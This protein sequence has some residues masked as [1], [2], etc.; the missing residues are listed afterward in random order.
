MG[1]YNRSGECLQCGTHWVLIYNWQVSSLKCSEEI[2]LSVS[3]NTVVCITQYSCLCHQ[4]LLS[5]SPNPN[6]EAADR[7]SRTSV[8]S[9]CLLETFHIRLYSVPH[10]TVL[11]QRSLEFMKLLKLKCYWSLWHTSVMANKCYLLIDIGKTGHFPWD[12]A[13]VKCIGKT[14]AFR[15]TFLYMETWSG[16][17]PNRSGEACEIGRVDRAE[18]PLQATH[19]RVL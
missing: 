9:V 16:Y 4:I 15:W 6:F 3:P 11:A 10:P 1:L 19:K 13:S 2:L 12:N 5:V 7:F 14:L 17:R 8:W 18:M